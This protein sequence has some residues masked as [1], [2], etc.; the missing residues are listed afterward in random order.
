MCFLTAVCNHTGRRESHEPFF[1]YTCFPTIFD[2]EYSAISIHFSCI[3]YTAYV[4]L[5]GNVKSREAIER[6]HDSAKFAV[7]LSCDIVTSVKDEHGNG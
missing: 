2:A 1:L 3:H 7:S 6:T 4:C 5:I